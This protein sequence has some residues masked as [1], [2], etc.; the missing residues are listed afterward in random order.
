MT[1]LARAWF[2]TFTLAV[3][4]C[5]LAAADAV[6]DLLRGEAVV[7]G[8]DNLEERARGIRQ[9]LTQVLVKLSG[10]DRIGEHPRLAAVLGDA[11]S[12]VVRLEY[13]DRGRGIDTVAGQAAPDR[14]YELHVEF[15]R[16]QM[17][18]ILG[19]LGLAPWQ[20]DRPRLLVVLSVTDGSGQ[21]VVGTESERGA[22]QRQ[23]LDTGARR[24]G[25]VLVMPK[26]DS[27]ETM[28]LSH[29][30]IAEAH[31]GALGALA[32]SYDADAVLSGTMAVT[33][34][35]SWNT[36]WTLLAD[37]M[38]VRWQVPNASFD[39]AIGLGL[40]QSARVLAGV[41]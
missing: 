28:A 30:E 21:F 19:R 39:R 3:A 13:E 8:R 27:V 1:R 37:G 24:R 15:D 33:S 38:P 35:G 9:A 4:P 40:G 25:L 10:D 22:G 41:K 36:D 34:D 32:T 17:H 29:G 5:A 7:T 6:P 18:A 26:M 14:S 12:Y 23:S 11:E 20:E 16:E 31:G 2:L